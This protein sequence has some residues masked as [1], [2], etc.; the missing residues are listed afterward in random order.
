MYT[1]IQEIEISIWD[2]NQSRFFP[3]AEYT[4]VVLSIIDC[5]L[6]QV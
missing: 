1:G 5:L 4:F 6:N 3:V 2:L